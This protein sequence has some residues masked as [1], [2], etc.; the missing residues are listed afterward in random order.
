MYRCINDCV[1]D[2]TFALQFLTSMPQNG[3]SHM[4]EPNVFRSR[5]MPREDFRR[6]DWS[7]HDFTGSVLFCSKF[8]SCVMKGSLF[9]K[10]DLQ[11]ANFSEAICTESDFSGADFTDA[12][13]DYGEFRNCIFD[14]AVFSE[15]SI[16]R[17]D[18]SG[19]TFIKTDLRCQDLSGADF[20][21][22]SFMDA[23]LPWPSLWPNRLSNVLS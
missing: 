14:G 15:T 5:R 9:R 7:G 11:G 6:S 3:E 1:E 10:A 21:G 4:N 12:I 22:C 8:Q 2:Q 23:I 18:F 17:A 13:L 19:S 16:L 20:F